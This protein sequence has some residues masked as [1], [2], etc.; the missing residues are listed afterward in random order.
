MQQVI[1]NQPFNHVMLAS[2]IVY[3]CTI[4]DI[5]IKVPSKVITWNNLQFNL[6]LWILGTNLSCM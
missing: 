5:A 6:V 4:L 2:R 1:D 3:T